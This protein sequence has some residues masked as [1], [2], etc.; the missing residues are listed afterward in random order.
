MIT[1]KQGV[2]RPRDSQVDHAIVRATRELLGERGYAGLTVGA[3]AERAGVGK[4][5]IYRRYATKQEMIFSAVVHDMQEQ[6]PPDTGSLRED[7]AALCG[8]IAAQLG[9]A[10]MDVLAGL[11]ADIYGDSSLAA[12]FSETFLARERLLVTEVLQRAVARGELAE[13][14]DPVTVQALLVGP[15]FVW[16]LM[17]MADRD[18]VPEF[19]RTVSES[20][21]NALL[22][23]V[24]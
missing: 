3:V 22:S 18:K 13:L 6:A 10:P 5:A 14:P 9:S 11:L 16:L 17:L 23:G 1:P 19:A 4:A 24:V 12:R 7:L 20:V 15:V 2:G 21:A 8:I